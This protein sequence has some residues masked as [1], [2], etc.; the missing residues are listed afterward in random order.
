MISILPCYD[1]LPILLS[2]LTVHT[3][4]D[5][6][7]RTFTVKAKRE[8]NLEPSFDY[9]TVFDKFKRVSSAVRLTDAT[10][11]VARL[12]LRQK[13]SG[14]AYFTD[15]DGN[16]KLDRLFVEQPGGRATWGTDRKPLRCRRVME[17]V[18]QFDPTWGSNCYGMKLSMFVTVDM[19]GASAIVAYHGT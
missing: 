11:L 8:G 9:Q 7:Y 6:H 4:S 14:L 3:A 15:D 5:V 17:K 16:G 12:A 13:A 18:L 19:D 10:N 1:H 2:H